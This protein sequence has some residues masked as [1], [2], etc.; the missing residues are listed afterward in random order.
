NTI[1]ADIFLN[2]QKLYALAFTA[3]DLI[4]MTHQTHFTFNDSSS[5]NN[6]VALSRHYFDEDCFDQE[7]SR[8][9][10]SRPPEKKR[11]HAGGKNEDPI[12]DYVNKDAALGQGFYMADS[13]E[14]DQAILKAWVCCGFSFNTIENP[15]IIDLF[16]LAIP[17]YILPSRYT[18]TGKLLDQKTIRIEKKIENELEK[19]DDLTLSMFSFLE[20]IS[21]YI[22][23]TPKRKEYL[24]KLKSYN[25]ESQTGQFIANEIQKIMQIIRI[26]KFAA[27]VTDNGSNLRV[28]R[29][30]VHEEYPFILNLRCASH[31]I[32]LLASD[33]TKIDS[34]KAIISDCNS[35][36]EFFNRSHAAHVYYKEQLVTMKIKGGEI[37]SYSK[38]QWVISNNRVYDL[39]QNEEFYSKCR[40]ISL[41]LKPIKNLTNILEARNANLA[42]CFVGLVK[43]GARLGLKQEALNKIYETASLIWYNLGHTESSCLSLLT[44]LKVW[45]R[46]E[47]PYNL[48][49]NQSKESPIKWWKSIN[50]DDEDDQKR[51][52]IYGKDIFENELKESSNNVQQIENS[53]NEDIEENTDLQERLSTNLSIS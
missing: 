16:K 14:L 1:P 46:Q 5:N 18:F 3:L 26:G 45:K 41:I 23:T 9:S 39:L 19:E 49:Y 50:V 25:T 35:I 10:T 6:N 36:L 48:S 28:A 17:G 13:N 34:I 40:Q 51:M 44:E 4:I 31:T 43:L 24:I 37:K 27:I 2:N 8:P 12:W 38:T 42:E 30:I 33:F 47:S 11:K 21:N 20:C 29:Q 22:I 52:K 15:F 53:E 7:P 32:N